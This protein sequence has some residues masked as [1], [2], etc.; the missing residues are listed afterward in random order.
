MSVHIQDD[1]PE[2]KPF[3]YYA[4]KVI[5]ELIEKQ[6]DPVER[7]AWAMIALRDGVVTAEQVKKFL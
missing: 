4:Q 6:P 7:K 5:L 3:G 1:Y 2:C